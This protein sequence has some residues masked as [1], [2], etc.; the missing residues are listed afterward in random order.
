MAKIKYETCEEH[1]K[2]NIFSTT[3]CKEC[4]KGGGALKRIKFKFNDEVK[5]IK[6]SLDKKGSNVL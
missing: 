3:D 6:R 4:T 5:N 2:L 1:Q